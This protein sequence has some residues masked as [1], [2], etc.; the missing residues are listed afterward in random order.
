MMAMYKGDVWTSPA[1][2]DVWSALG[3][4]HFYIYYNGNLE[5]M[6][7]ETPAVVDMLERHP[8]VTLHSWPY[9][10]RTVIVDPTGK[11]KLPEVNKYGKG[12]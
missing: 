12:K 1:W 11:S 9:P 4:G 6:R 2:F 8:K 10:M 5:Q 3:I 7:N